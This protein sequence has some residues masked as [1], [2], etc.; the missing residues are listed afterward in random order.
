MRYA[1]LDQFLKASPKALSKGPIAMILAEDLVE[2]DST[3]R[4]HLALGFAKMILLAPASYQAPP[5]LADQIVQIDHDFGQDN[6][7]QRAVNAINDAFH[8]LGTCDPRGN[9][10]R[11]RKDGQRPK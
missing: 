9:Q 2:I 4:H 6:A 10:L 7:T 5:V 8:K 3:I 11:T 1:T